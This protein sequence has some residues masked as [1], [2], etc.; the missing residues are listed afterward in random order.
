MTLPDNWWLASASSF[1]MAI[2][3]LH[4]VGGG[5]DHHDPMLR[6]TIREVDK[7]VWFVLWHF[8]TAALFLMAASLLASAYGQIPLAYL[9]LGLSIAFSVLFLF[10]SWRRFRNWLALPQWTL[11]VVLSALIGGGL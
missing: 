4:I 5:R 10:E 9:P 8:T 1:A 11:F 6:S 3:F 2:A 7:G